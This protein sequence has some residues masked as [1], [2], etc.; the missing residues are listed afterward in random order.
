[1]LDLYEDMTTSKFRKRVELEIKAVRSFAIVGDFIEM[2]PHIGAGEISDGVARSN[3][4]GAV[5]KLYLCA[6]VI[7]IEGKSMTAK[8]GS[9]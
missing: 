3:S 6:G 9:Q 7:Q 2:K 8:M 4:G 1:M 5:L